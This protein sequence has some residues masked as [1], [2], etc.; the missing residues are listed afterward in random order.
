MNNAPQ[1]LADEVL[2]SLIGQYA[3]RDFIEELRRK[4]Q[5]PYDELSRIALWQANMW[6]S[7]DYLDAKE[8]VGVGPGYFIQCPHCNAELGVRDGHEGERARCHRCGQEFTIPPRA[9]P[10]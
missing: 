1:G 8:A 10:S 2:P 7:V 5:R 9:R 4:G 3:D 6:N